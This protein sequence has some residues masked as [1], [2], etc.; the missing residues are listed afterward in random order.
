MF[1]HRSCK[2]IWLHEGKNVCLLFR[3]LSRSILGT[4]E[5]T[6]WRRSRRTWSTSLSTDISGLH[7]QTQKCMQNT[8]REPTGVPDQRKRIYRPP[9][10]SVGWRNYGVKWSV[11]WTGS[12]LSGWGNWSRSP[13]PTLGQLSES[14]EKHLRL[15]V[16][17]MVCGSL[18]GM[19]IRQSLPQPYIPWT[20]M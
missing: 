10:N 14:E 15:R 8:N 7:L 5:R 12:A 17:Q 18:N 20:G 19:K 13:M 16:K 11:S 1:K 9:Q 6:R 2:A 4:R 3:P